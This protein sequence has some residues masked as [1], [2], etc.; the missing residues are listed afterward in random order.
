VSDATPC[1]IAA[2]QFYPYGVDALPV[3][4]EQRHSIQFVGL[5]NDMRMFV[6]GKQVYPNRRPFPPQNILIN[7]QLGLRF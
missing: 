6:D 5:G 2:N 7:P 3:E 4:P 1:H